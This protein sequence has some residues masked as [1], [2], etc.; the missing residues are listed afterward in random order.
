MIRAPHGIESSLWGTSLG[1][2]G[3]SGGRETKC[4]DNTRENEIRF[5]GMRA[6]KTYSTVFPGFFFR[7]FFGL[8]WGSLA[9]HRLSLIVSSGGDSLSQCTGFSLRDLPGPGIKPMSPALVGGF[10]FS[11]TKDPPGF[12]LFFPHFPISY[13]HLITF[14]T[15]LKFLLICN[16]HVVKLTPLE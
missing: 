15:I 9:A 3:E 16:S 5:G 11:A 2:R 10:L 12:L 13:S 8:C 1:G 6:S 7:L 14:I 4:N